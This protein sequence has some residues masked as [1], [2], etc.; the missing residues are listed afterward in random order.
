V[1]ELKNIIAKNFWL[2][3][4]AAIAVCMA[5]KFC[6]ADTKQANGYQDILIE[7]VP[8]ILQKSDFC[9]EACAEMYLKK[10]GFSH[11]QN[12]VFNLSGLSPIKGRGCNTAELKTALTKIGFEAG[13][14]WYYI[15]ANDAKAQVEQ[16]FKNLHQDLTKQIPSIVCMHYDDNS[17]TEHFRL[18]LG[19]DSKTDSIIYHEPAAEKS[20]Y[21]KMPR[22]KF[23][24]LW[25]LKYDKKKWTIIRICLKPNKI[26]NPVPAI[27]F[28][29][30]DYA[31]HIMGLNKLIPD[32]K[33]TTVLQQPFVVI[34]NEDST[35]VRSRAVHTVQWAVDKLKA[36][37]F[38]NDPCSIIDIWL[39]KNDQDYTKYAKEIFSDNPTT[40]FG[41]FSSA[42]NALIMNIATGGGTLVHEMVHPF[43]AANFP[44]CPAWFNE[45]LASLYE[46]SSEKNG[47]IVGLT[48]WRLAG[49]QQK[50]KAGKLPSF[51]SLC[52]TT[53]SE[54]YGGTS[55]SDNYAQARYLCYYLQENGLLTKF[56]HEFAANHTADTGGYKTLRN[57]LG[58]PDMNDFQKTWQNWV[59]PL[60]FP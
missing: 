57:V 13:Q 29:D 27:G 43:I 35:T 26:K 39:F 18:I 54:F 51:E 21:H 12:D 45:G 1:K 11:T 55:Y 23:I 22:E 50:I 3:L 36:D 46:Q 44:D 9:G 37:Y 58:Q 49:L 56:Y 14:V 48:N 38:K 31:Q 7:N 25:P 4:F 15:D 30:A 42:H 17:T 8:H 16:Q 33:F 34:G 52:K 59:L 60:T 6:N 53:S 5:F 47:R 41:Y 32:D 20:D 24:D 28:T 10:L 2:Y 19:Y 40:P